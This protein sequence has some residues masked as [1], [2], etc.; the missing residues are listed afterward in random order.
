MATVTNTF[1]PNTKIKSASVNTNFTDLTDTRTKSI[2]LP[3]G[4][5]IKTEGTPTET[6]VD[7][8]GSFWSMTV[9]A[10]DEGI[11][12]T[13][14]IPLDWASGDINAYI[15]WGSNGTVGDAVLAM[16]RTSWITEGAG[17]FDAGAAEPSIVDTVPGVSR[18]LKIASAINLGTPGGVNYYMAF[19]VT[20]KG[21]S[22][23]DTLASSL[24]IAGVRFDYTAYPIY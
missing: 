7:G 24:R 4:S 6:G 19:S 22:A 13:L 9:T 20:R 17:A 3:S 1:S 11:G 8:L 12:S 21:A 18:Q 2:W 10:T 23:S 16:R 15:Y 14:I 5:F